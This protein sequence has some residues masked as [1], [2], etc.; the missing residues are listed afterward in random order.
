MELITSEVKSRE[1]AAIIVTHD[2][3]VTHHADH[4]VE[5]TDGHLA[6]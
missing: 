5:I 4:S 1:T 3:R 2:T 6:A